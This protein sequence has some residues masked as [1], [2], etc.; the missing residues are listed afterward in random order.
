[1]S[2][3]TLC[4]M[5]HSQAAAE[6][7]DGITKDIEKPLTDAGIHQLERVRQFIKDHRLKPDLVICSHAVR[8]RQTLEW[9]QEALGGTVEVQYTEALYGS[10]VE[11]LFDEISNIDDRYQ[12]VWVIGHNPSI[13]DGMQRLSSLS[14]DKG[15][16]ELKLPAQPAQLTV[17]E[18]KS[19]HWPLLVSEA[20][21]LK[22]LFEPVYDQ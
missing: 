14:V 3:K 12:H 18:S 4:L 17:F 11:A 22:N 21:T 5:R 7:S 13:T 10:G 6:L 1:M 2:L 20:L 19:Q 8:T 9:I 16:H 15:Q